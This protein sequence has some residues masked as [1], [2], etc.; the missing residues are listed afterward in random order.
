MLS[1]REI[2]FSRENTP[3]D[4][5]ISNDQPENMHPSDIIQAEK[6]AFRNIYVYKNICTYEFNNN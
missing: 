3:T 6:V 5:L 2:V 4:Y 1:V